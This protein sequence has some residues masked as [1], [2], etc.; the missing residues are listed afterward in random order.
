MVLL[1]KVEVMFIQSTKII[2]YWI[3]DNNKILWTQQ[4]FS[5]SLR[6]HISYHTLNSNMSGR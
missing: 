6:I 1:G 4:Y 2:I 3:I 5:Y